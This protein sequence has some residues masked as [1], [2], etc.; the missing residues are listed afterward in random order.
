MTMFGR[1]RLLGIVLL[2][3]FGGVMSWA[4]TRAET[5]V[6]DRYV[7]NDAFGVG[8]WLEFSIGYGFLDAGTA[9]MEV[10]EVVDVEGRPVYRI[11]SIATSNHV[12][13]AF[14]R[15]RDT[16]LSLVDVE[17]IFS[18]RYEN[19][20]HEGD[21]RRDLIV[22]FEQHLGI[23]IDGNDTLEIPAYVQD[24]MSAFYYVRTQELH[25]GDT[26][27]VPNLTN[28]QLYDVRVIVHGQERIETPAGEFDCVKVEPI[29]LE[30][31]IFRQKGHVFI[32]LTDDRLHMPVLVKSKL[33]IGAIRAELTGYRFGELWEE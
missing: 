22:R 27:A 33:V 6:L 26:L 13:D 5:R 28:K 12:F 8:E 9:T 30:T 20:Q 3:L 10:A 14:Y 4:S 15:V 18:W 21:Y 11:T 19:R 32:W 24:V 7:P 17:G 23:A 29:L 2:L 16:I 31:G 1:R 25:V